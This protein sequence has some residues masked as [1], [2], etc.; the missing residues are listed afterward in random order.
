MVYPR[1]MEAM[2]YGMDN[3]NL[4]EELTVCEGEFD[5]MI[6][7]DHGIQAVTSTA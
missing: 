4:S 2:L 7:S 1:K 5:Q 6:L 3:I